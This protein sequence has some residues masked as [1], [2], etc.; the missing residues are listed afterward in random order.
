MKIAEVRA[1]A[2]DALGKELLSAQQQLLRLCIR[3]KTGQ[4]DKTHQFRQLR[5]AIARMKTVAN[6]RIRDMESGVQK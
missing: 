2:G 5:R 3:R 4:V 1:L 6:Q